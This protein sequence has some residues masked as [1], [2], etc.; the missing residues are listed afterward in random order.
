MVLQSR[1]RLKRIYSPT[2]D[3]ELSSFLQKLEQLPVFATVDMDDAP[4]A[5]D[6]FVL[7]HL[8]Q[9]YRLRNILPVSYTH[10]TL[11]TIYSV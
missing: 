5:Q 4:M 8:I 11:P 3:A 10:L 1:I 2:F 9:D 6:I 7:K